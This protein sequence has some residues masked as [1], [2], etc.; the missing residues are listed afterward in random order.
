MSPSH[1]LFHCSWTEGVP[2]V[3]LE[4]FAARLPVVATA[5]GG[6][7]EA[8]GGAALLV[9]PGDAGGP[10]CELARVAADPALRERMIEAG[11]AH[12]CEHTLE[13]EACRVAQFLAGNGDR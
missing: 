13:R 12:A 3:L 11:L 5:V 4:A 8:S 2:Q 6:V 7:A 9:R 1:A 10:A